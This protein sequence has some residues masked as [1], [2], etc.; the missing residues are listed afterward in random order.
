MSV[1]IELRRIADRMDEH[2]KQHNREQ[3]E[4]YIKYKSCSDKFETLFR[5]MGAG[6]VI[7]AEH[8]TKI[9]GLS[10][11]EKCQDDRIEALSQKMDRWFIG[12]IGLAALGYLL[13]FIF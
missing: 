9:N 12:V 2:E 10:S 13:S 6:A 11:R 7:D 1:E 8:K 5:A 3:E 4:R